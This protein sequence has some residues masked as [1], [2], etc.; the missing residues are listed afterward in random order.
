M[1]ELILYA[2]SVMW[3]P[4]PVNTVI[5]NTGIR[6]G[7]RKVIPF[8]VGVSTAMSAL[9][10]LYGLLGKTIE[11][12]VESITFYT[13]IIGSI[14][15]IYLA[16]KLL[17]SNINLDESNSFELK[18]KQG[19]F[20]QLFNP[21]GTL[22]ALPIATIYLPKMHTT[23]VYIFFIGILIGIIGGTGV[24]VI[25][26][27]TGSVFKQIIKESKAF[28]IINWIMALILIYLSITLIYDHIIKVLF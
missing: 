4:G 16:Y 6:Q 1:K 7:A 15:M 20:M 25:Y 10:I 19:F 13:S 26:A 14:Y 18:F 22:C 17:K 3:T 11:L 8:V 23:W 12:Y 9:I 24:F 27:L 5:L 2:I 21:K 28:V